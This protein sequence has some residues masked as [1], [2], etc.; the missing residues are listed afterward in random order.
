ML[1]GRKQ[2]TWGEL[3]SEPSDEAE[4]QMGYSDSDAVPE[5]EL[6]EKTCS[7]FVQCKGSQEEN[8]LRQTRQIVENCK[9]SWSGRQAVYCLVI[10]QQRN[11]K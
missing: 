3:C 6:S 5:I 2:L 9:G 8:R 4:A 7:P 1:A 11:R 10:G